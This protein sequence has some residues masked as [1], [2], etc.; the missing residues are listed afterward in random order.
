MAGFAHFFDN[1]VAGSM[2]GI[3]QGGLTD[4]G[5]EVFTTLEQRGVIID[6]THASHEAVATMLDMATNPVVLSNGGVQGTCDNNRN[7]TDD[8]IRGVAATGGVMG[9]AT[10]RP[11]FAAWNSTRF[12]TR[13]T[14]WWRS[15]AS[16]PPRSA[17][18]STAP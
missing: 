8:E 7:V 6:L 11:P 14:T 5:R 16:R 17:A 15:A 9:S 4:F 18:T 3:E 12:W 10:S 13:S 2:H 1:D